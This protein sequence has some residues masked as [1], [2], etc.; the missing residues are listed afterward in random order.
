M[1]K[2]PTLHTESGAP[3]TAVAALRNLAKK[4]SA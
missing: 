4:E 1:A 2:R 3:V